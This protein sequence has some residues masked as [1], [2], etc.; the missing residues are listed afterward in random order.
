MKRLYYSDEIVNEIDNLEH[1]VIYGA[2]TMGRA[3]KL[4]LES[5]VYKKKV[6]CFLV[7]SLENN[8]SDIDGCPVFESSA[9]SEK[10]RKIIVALNE[11]NLVSAIQALDEEGFHNLII[12]NASGDSWSYLKGNYFRNYNKSL[13]LP[14]E[15]VKAESNS[16]IENAS[17]KIYIAKSI[18]D[19][20]IG[21]EEALGPY[22]ANI[23]VGAALTDQA[24]CDIQDNV[25]DNIS[26]KNR[27]YCEL[28]AL[29]WAWK[30]D[31]SDYVGLSHYRRRFEVTEG[32]LGW[33][34]GNKVDV[35]VTIPVI[36]TRGIGTQY[37][38]DHAERD[39]KI[40]KEEL[41]KIHPL[42]DDAFDVCQEQIY[43][44]PC[45][46]FIMK[47]DVLNE[48]CEWLFPLLFA[49][50]ARIGLKDDAYQNRYVGFLAERLLNV[51]LYFNRDRLRICVAKRRY[52]TG[53]RL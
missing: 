29:Y 41:H 20:K 42:Y 19:K 10:E 30:N 37:C 40:L 23:Q 25:G 43:F 21:E 39:W 17:L 24:I 12:L 38:L 16:I 27:Q 44:Y 8:P 22:E 26:F 45:N 1:I 13:Y 32:E 11:K 7:H 14:F 4:C 48:Y 51:Y 50:E 47:R 35:V 28:T 49:C 33:I 31:P 52:L 36:N 18:Y 34:I 3:L 53:K 2:G 15:S 9:Y 6:E 5:D 46:M